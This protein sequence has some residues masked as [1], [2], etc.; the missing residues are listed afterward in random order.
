MDISVFQNF[1][2]LTNKIS[3]NRFF[4]KMIHKIQN[5]QKFQ[6]TVTYVIHLLVV[7]QCTQ[8]QVNSS[9]FDPQMEC[10]RLR[11]H[12]Y[13]LRH[14]FKCDFC[15]FWGLYATTNDTIRFLSQNWSR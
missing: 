14:F 3:K 10:F 13:S 15:N 9:I 1:E 4:W 7:Y 2:F 5:I 6:K 12:T 11:N 8:F